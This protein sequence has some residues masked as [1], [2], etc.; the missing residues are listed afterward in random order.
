MWDFEHK[1]FVFLTH[2]FCCNTYEH[3][4]WYLVV[5]GAIDVQSKSCINPRLD[6]IGYKKSDHLLIGIDSSCPENLIRKAHRYLVIGGGGVYSTFLNLPQ[7]NA[8]DSLNNDP[9]L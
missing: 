8:L 6:K 9:I 3:N 2:S 5:P 1:E 4:V 7:L